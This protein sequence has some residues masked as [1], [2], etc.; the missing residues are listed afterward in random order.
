[1]YLLYSNVTVSPVPATNTGT[2]TCAA[3][4]ASRSGCRARVEH[5]MQVHIIHTY[6]IH[7]SCTIHTVP[8]CAIVYMKHQPSI[9]TYPTPNS[10]PPTFQPPNHML[11]ALNTWFTP[12]PLCRVGEAG[13]D[14]GGWVAGETW[15]VC[16]A[17][18]GAG[19]VHGLSL[20]LAS[21][22]ITRLGTYS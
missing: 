14:A 20:I 16:R 19:S 9:H 10:Q 17:P 15:A 3:L 21:L 4:A 22:D 11:G 2:N 18:S 5:G 7:M 13:K 12:P 1:M 6:L 8:H